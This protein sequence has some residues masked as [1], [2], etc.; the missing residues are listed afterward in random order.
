MVQEELRAVKGELAASHREATTVQLRQ[1][2]GRAEMQVSHM[3]PSS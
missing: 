3:Q 2:A 1:L